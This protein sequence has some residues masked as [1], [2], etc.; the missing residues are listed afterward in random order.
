MSLPG[1][2][3]RFAV[4]ALLLAALEFLLF[5]R[6]ARGGW[7][8]EP[9]QVHATSAHCPLV[10]VCDDASYGAIVVWQENTAT[11]GL[12][13]VQHL[14]ASGDLDPAWSG[15]VPV[16]DRDAARAAIGTVSDGAGGAYVWWLENT[17]IY[18][19]HIAADGTVAPGWPAR[20][21]FIGQFPS[22]QHRPRVIADG[23]GGIY[24]AWFLKNLF[25]YSDPTSI[26]VLRLGPLGG[27]VGG[28]PAGGRSFGLVGLENPSVTSFAMDRSPDG[29]L[30]LGWLTVE[31]VQSY[32]QPGEIRALR[33]GPAGLPAPGWTLEGAALGTYDQAMSGATSLV[34]RV[35]SHIA[36]ASDGGEGAYLL[37]GHGIASESPEVFRDRL[38]HLD[39]AGSPAVGWDPAGLDLG[40]RNDWSGT[41]AGEN[42]SM[43]AFSDGRGGVYVGLPWYA[44]EFTSGIEFTR[45]DGSGSPLPG[46]TGANQLGL[47]F[48]ARGDGGMSIASF[49]SSGPNGLNDGTAYIGLWQ[50]T[51][52][53]SFF[54][55]QASPSTI[56]Y[57]DIGLA[58]TGDG[59][60]IFTWSELI[61]R[62]GVFAIRLNPSGI[63]TDVPPTTTARGA[64][65]WYARGVGVQLLMDGSASGWLRLHDVTGREVARGEWESGALARWTVPGTA[66]LPSGVYFAVG[67]NG[68]TD[69]KSR[70]VII[71]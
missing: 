41:M 50:S 70:V 17:L 28:W 7:G 57:G 55:Y 39:G 71:H 35:Q 10:S 32:P 9:V 34:P 33:L 30:W 44:T 22:S 29:G 59:G 3:I 16:S 61:D 67:R 56:R 60:A 13:K 12:L 20:G 24:F 15:A 54:E 65:L 69:F 4:I 48:A 27:A 19:T 66:E 2:R 43:R 26:R 63:V 1:H 47:E 31:L 5:T 36:V 25:T 6:P 46:G 23:S 14:L 64:R 49:K 53:A 62:Q 52:G 51:P 37:S 11:G 21:R 38:F 18:L 68:A 58:P 40:E 42:T 45:Y 8:V